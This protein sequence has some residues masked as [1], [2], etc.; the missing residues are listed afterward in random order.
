M[1]DSI[2]Q[3]LA[4]AKQQLV[5][6]KTKAL[7]AEILLAHILEVSRDYLFA[8]PERIFTVTEVDKSTNLIKRRAYGEPIAYIINRKEFWSLTLTVTPDTLIPRPETELLIEIGLQ[9]LAK[10]E[11]HKIADLGTGS[12][13][14][15]L[16]MAKEF[17][18]S[19]ITAIDN[20]LAAL[21]IAETNALDLNI[22]NV[23]FSLSDWGEAL[24]V[25]EYD[26]I[27][28]N[29]PYIDADDSCLNDSEICFEPRCALV[30]ENRGMEAIHKIAKQARKHLRSGGYLLIEHGSTQGKEVRETLEKFKYKNI[31]TVKDLLKLERVT[32]AVMVG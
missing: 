15:A 11:A 5:S 7:D 24:E 1:N 30:A 26:M 28:T 10:E 18:H 23:K 9:L 8:C 32:F 4:E 16:A 13:A 31:T 14:I 29:P 19:Q 25:K 22:K 20:S 2:T 12:G 6:S 3:V 21:K 27:L 17:P